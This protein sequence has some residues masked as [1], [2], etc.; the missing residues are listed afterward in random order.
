[1]PRRPQTYDDYGAAVQQIIITSS[2][3]DFLDQLIP[4]LKD[5]SHSN[6]TPSLMQ[7]LVRYAED[8]ESDIERIGLTKHE[9]FLGSVNQLQNVREG[10]VTLTAEIL[11]LNQ[12]IQASTEKL[13]DQKQ[14]L[15][16]TRAVRQ[17]IADA[18]DALKE[19]LKIL[20]AVNHAHDLIRTKKYYAALKSLE[21]LQNEHLIPTIQNKYATQ[22]R[23]AD[24]IQK[25]IPASQK[26]ISEAVM[27]DLNTWLFRIR[28][29]SQFL[30][31]VAFYHTELRRARQRE[32]VERDSFL[33]NFRLNS[34]IELV[35]DESEEFDVL[36][37]EELRVDFTPLFECLHI[38]NALGQ[39]EKFRAEYATTRRQQK[40]LLLPSTVN[41]VAEDESS[42][43]SL[44]EGIAGFA[45]IE[46]ATMRRVPNLRSAVDVDEL[47]DSMCHTAITLTS[48]AL[49][50]VSNAEILLK[51]KGVIALFIQTMEGWGYSVSM[52][53][54]F[55]LTLFD[56]YAELLKRRFSEDFQEIVSTDD[57]M[58]MAINT[59]EE[60]EKVV[61]VSWFSQEKPLEELSF[62]CVLP[63]S[64]MYPLCC[65][66]I[67]NFLNQFYFFS[68]DHFQHPNSL[69]E[70]LTEKVCK[71]LVERL[72]SQYLGQIVQILINLEHFEAAC[73][74]LEQLL[75]RARS[76]T[77]AGGPVTLV[78][79][80]EFRNNKKTAEKRIFE[81]VNS[82]I[83]D[84]VD[85]AEYD[86]M[87]TTTSPD[88]SSYMQT[89]TRYLSTIMNSTLLGLPR[90][91]K[92]LIY[93]DALSHAA[94]KILALPLSPDVKHINTNAV[95]ALAKDVQYLT[96]FVDSLENGAMLRENLDELQQTINLMQS[97][98]HD[99][100]FDIS[101][102][103]KKFGR[104]DALNGPI[105][106]E[107]LTSNAQGPTRS[108]PLANFSSRFGMMK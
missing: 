57:Y 66:D 65:I 80:E 15:V 70:L 4:V 17:N 83:D 93:F 104:V 85:T 79:T 28:E 9:E 99:E 89:M 45:I 2:D 76:S 67:R 40:D 38:H 50:E 75:I 37:N 3:A 55:L 29:T 51:I 82:K 8:R 94:N 72:S 60:Y 13:A 97:D 5:A 77:S 36:D 16:N 35:F 44:L 23:L 18:S 34:S 106:L 59:R 32:R 62:P 30:G 58:P 31:E 101:I 92:E 64:Q 108:A 69:D 27:T 78:A 20:H 24:V 49:N 26:I 46:K 102:R 12:S 71:S 52:L 84:L 10:T 47:W 53:D 74:E 73:Q 68:D 107:K 42:L 6:R 90:E 100:F 105:L 33:N 21:D 87:V 39:S 88:P 48:Q 41:L 7:N 63:F 86:W 91:I 43:S 61:N 56:K 103:N 98:N 1:M 25:S 81:L 22:H 19:S 95:A 54:N 96:E 11:R 14:A